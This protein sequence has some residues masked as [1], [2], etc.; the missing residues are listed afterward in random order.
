MAETTYERDELLMTPR[1]V[2]RISLAGIFTGAFCALGLG[3][4]FL[5]FG[6]AL[7]VLRFTGPM[8]SAIGPAVWI[9]VSV[10]VATYIG[11]AAG[12]K[13]SG[14]AQRRDGGMQGMIT[15]ALA[16]FLT[17][18]FLGS[19][20]AGAAGAL[21][22]TPGAAAGAAEGISP[23]NVGA[24]SWSFFITAVAGLIGGVLGGLSGAP[25]HGE[26]EKP[27]G[28]RRHMPG[29]LREREV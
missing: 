25:T 5:S 14:V 28:I 27:Y 1:A 3:L 21:N 26:H 16:F 15:W 11:A 17:L 19:I 22:V 8:S 7:G 10:F 20:A 29:S 2:H 18:V 4:L 12:V 23:E 6:V 13:S 24:A 9:L